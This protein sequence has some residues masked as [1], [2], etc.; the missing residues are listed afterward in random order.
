MCAGVTDLCS[1]TEDADCA[2]LDSDENLC[3]GSFTCGGGG[4]CE[5]LED[6][7]LCDDEVDDPCKV[8]A[9]DP[10]TGS[11]IVVPVADGVSCVDANPCTQNEICIA[12]E[13]TSDPVEC[14][15]DIP[16]TDDLCDPDNGG[17]TFE[18]VH[19]NCSDEVSCTDNTCDPTQGCVFTPNASACDDGKPCTKDTCVP[20]SGC[21]HEP[22]DSECDDGVLCTEDSCSV[23][24]GCV[25]DPESS[26]CGDGNPCTNDLCLGGEGCV[27]SPTPGPCEDGN[28]CT[29]DDVCSNGVCTSGSLKPCESPNGCEAGQCEPATGQ[30]SFI[31]LAD[32]TACEDGNACSNPDV[33]DGGVCKAGPNDPCDDGIA[34]TV[35]S[36]DEVTGACKSALDGGH[37][38]VDEACVVAGSLSPQNTCLACQPATS[39]TAYTLRAAGSP[40][41]DSDVCTLNDACDGSGGCSGGQAQVCDDGLAC[42]TET[43]V[44]EG[45]AGCVS[46]LDSGSCVIDAACVAAGYQAAFMAPTE[47]LARQHYEGIAALAEK[48]GVTVSLLTGKTRARERKEIEALFA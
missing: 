37:C 17:C 25:F 23:D 48:A 46:T 6:P 38:L 22:V 16:C 18:P 19:E 7:V 21:L 34:C 10:E 28:L 32:G 9:C 30:C 31:V 3:N 24:F 29:V 40:C 45:A 44:S 27:Y 13:C 36:C 2:P 41:D 11:C 4:S 47:I 15:D 8:S 42:T 12:G 39:D 35:D 14:A 43:C 20:A 26:N 1:C 5:P 33:C